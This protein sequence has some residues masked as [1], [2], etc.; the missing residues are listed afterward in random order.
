MRVEAKEQD[1]IDIKMKWKSHSLHAY[2]KR[3]K[4]NQNWL[5]E[6]INKIHILLDSVV[7]FFKKRINYKSLIPTE[8]GKNKDL[9]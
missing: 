1:M 2:R 8:C 9:I 7:G 4:E 5:F 3:S 6:V